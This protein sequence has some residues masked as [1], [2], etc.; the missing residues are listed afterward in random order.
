MSID[1]RVS[2]FNILLSDTFFGGTL[3]VMFKDPVQDNLKQTI[4]NIKARLKKQLVLTLEGVS[5]VSSD[6]PDDFLFKGT[7]HIKNSVLQN[8]VL[9][10]AVIKDCTLFS[11]K[12]VSVINASV[13]GIE[14]N[15]SER[16]VFG[17]PEEVEKHEPTNPPVSEDSLKEAHDLLTEDE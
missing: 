11:P 5:V 1:V 15:T 3:L 12:G 6:E 16:Q 10:D 8:P 2:G 9:I 7:V 4:K 17:Q 13:I 14:S